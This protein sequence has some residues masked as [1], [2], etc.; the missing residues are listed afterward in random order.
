MTI[1]QARPLPRVGL[2][3]LFSRR[4]R[5]WTAV[6]SVTLFGVVLASAFLMPLAYMAA[7]SLKDAAQMSEQNAPLYPAKP[8]TFQ[9]EGG[10][11]PVYLVPTAE[12]VRR[13]A[14]VDA[15][16]EDSTFVDPANTAA[17]PIEW[18]GRWRTLEQAW[19][20]GLNLENFATVWNQINFARL[21]FNTFANS[22]APNWLPGSRK[23][24]WPALR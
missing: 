9:W 4:V 5:A 2:H 1:A 11:Y 13:W 20:F 21:L 12:G 24:T 7:T 3:G 14:L 22:S 8:A 19:E 23:T 15:R 18:Q 17:G 16:R 6:S 10:V